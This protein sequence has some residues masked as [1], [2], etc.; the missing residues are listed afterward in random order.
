MADA[1]TPKWRRYRDL[2]RP[3]I[4]ADVSKVIHATVQPTAS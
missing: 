2:V 4:A 3:N 1:D